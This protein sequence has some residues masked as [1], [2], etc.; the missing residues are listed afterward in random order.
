M[1]SFVDIDMGWSKQAPRPKSFGVYVMTCSLVEKR[2]LDTVEI[3][4]SN[5]I[6]ST[7]LPG[8]REIG[9][10]CSLN[11]RQQVCILMGSFR[12]P[13]HTCKCVSD[14]NDNFTCDA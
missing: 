10:M 7:N 14:A 6:R 4:S 13:K 5:L 8:Q 2:H 12:R 3:M 11:A 1:L 9:C